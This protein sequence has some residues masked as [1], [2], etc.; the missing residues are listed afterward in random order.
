[1]S[2]SEDEEKYLRVD[3]PVLLDLQNRYRMVDPRIT[4]PLIWEPGLVTET[5]L[6]FFRGDNAY[7]WQLRGRNL[8]F[9]SYVV[10]TYYLKA[11]DRTGLFDRL[12]E[13]EKFG[14]LTYLL[15]NRRVSRDLLD[16]IFELSFLDRHLNI[17]GRKGLRIL[18]IGA[19]YGRL[20]SRSVRALP[21]L[22]AYLCTDGVAVS[23]FLCDFY[24]R[25]RQVQSK[26]KVVPLDEVPN[27]PDL[28]EI[29]LAINIHSFSEC[30]LE[31]IDW[32]VAQLARRSV[33]YIF[34]V[35]NA[36]RDNGAVLCT[37]DGVEFTDILLRHGYRLRV[38][39]PKFLQPEIQELGLCPTYYFLFERA[40]GDPPPSLSL[41]S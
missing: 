1:V 34:I 10:T 26:A 29:D 37:N 17:T 15:D 5:D 12:D 21:D 3:N 16:S 4:T 30:R 32:W 33:P 35:P 9:V 19:G 28:D 14:A 25:H 23:S 36:V 27:S 18:D 31:T 40:V 22:G 24:L 13:D 41:A 11:L 20:A 8:S 6:K 7:V 39:E 38:K 2:L